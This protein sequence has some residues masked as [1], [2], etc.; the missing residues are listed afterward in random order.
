MSLQDKSQDWQNN[1]QN[2]DHTVDLCRKKKAD[3]FVPILDC[4]KKKK[5]KNKEKK[6]DN[7]G[8]MI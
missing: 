4:Q 5:K 1:K 7:V 8:L 6:K 2:G 3:N